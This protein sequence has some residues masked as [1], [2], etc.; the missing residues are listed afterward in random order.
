MRAF[1]RLSIRDLL[2]G[3]AFA[4][5]LSASAAPVAAKVA[6]ASDR[7][8][9]VR[10]QVEVPVSP[11][12]AWSVLLKPAEWWSSQHTWSGSAANLSVDPRPGGCFCE[13][14]PDPASSAASPRGGVEHMRIVFVD[15]ARTLRM[16]GALGPLQPDAATGTMTIQLKPAD[17]GGHT[18]IWLEYVVGGYLRTPAEKLAPAVDGVLG[19]QIGRLAAKLGGEAAAVSPEQASK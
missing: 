16:T 18:Q 2:S 9:I 14:L 19:E 8:F 17:G 15:N 13:V 6:E 5:A 10:H 4:L 3:L 12:Q 11:A 7:G 1:A